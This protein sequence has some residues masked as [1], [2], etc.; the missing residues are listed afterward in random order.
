MDKQMQ[1]EMET[2]I[3]KGHIGF[4]VNGFTQVPRVGN[5]SGPPHRFCG[6][7]TGKRRYGSFSCAFGNCGVSC[8][9]P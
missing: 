2:G 3:V 1:D 8:V 6:H 9:A 4:R 7:Q 5:S